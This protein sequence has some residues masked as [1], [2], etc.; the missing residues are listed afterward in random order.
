M[1]DAWVSGIINWWMI[2][3]FTVGTMRSCGIEWEKEEP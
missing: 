1:D 2:V 3:P